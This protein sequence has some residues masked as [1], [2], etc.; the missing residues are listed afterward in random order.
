MPK[1]THLV[2]LLAVLYGCADPTGNP[3]P[4]T[5]LERNQE[6]W[7]QQNISTYTY[8]FQ[9][10]CFCGLVDPVDVTV[11]SGV[12]TAVVV[13][14]SQEELDPSMFDQFYTVDGLF[15][16]VQDA[17]DGDA[18]D[19]RAEVP[20]PSV[21]SLVAAVDL[22]DIAD[23]RGTVGGQR[24]NKH[25]HPGPNVRTLEPSSV[26]PA[27]TADDRPVGIAERNPSAHGN[28]LVDKEESVL[29]HLL[30]D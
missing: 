17:L 3:V 13:A 8:R 19:P 30:E 14:D 18:L 27:R 4:L 21:D 5:A 25:R 24:G 11:R 2:T 7:A 6:R 15:Q 28:K 10:I 26:K 1:P 23:L 29:E 12:I 20:Q 22:S 9:R 16:V